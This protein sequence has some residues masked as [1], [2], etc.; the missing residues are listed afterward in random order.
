MSWGVAFLAGLVSFLSPCVAPIV[1]GYL[2][3]ISGAAVG[4]ERSESRRTERVAIASLLFVLGF[5]TVFVALGATAGAV[6]MVLGEYRPILTRAAG[7]VMVLMGLF[8]LGLI[9]VGALQRERRIHLIDRPYG[10]VGTVLLGMAFGFGWTPCIGPVLAGI[11]FYAGAAETAQTGAVLLLLYSV[12]LGF[13]FVL[14]A[15]GLS[16]ALVST[17][18]ARRALPGLNGAAGALLVITGA[19]FL[20]NQAVY[21]AYLNVAT[22]RLLEAVAR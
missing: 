19:L 13:P 7:G 6:G 17:A 5:S 10:P 14:S 21:L 16:R 4:V 8:T 15:L 2:S 20:T 1:P 22:Q 9:R 12:G 18:W 11:L 3:F